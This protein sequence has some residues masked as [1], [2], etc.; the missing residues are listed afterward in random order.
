[1][2]IK[3]KICN[4]ICNDLLRNY[5]MV[6]IKLPLL[7]LLKYSHNLDEWDKEIIN[8]VIKCIDEILEF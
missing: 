3:F 2:G 4:W 8:K 1:M 6:G 7:S 5:L